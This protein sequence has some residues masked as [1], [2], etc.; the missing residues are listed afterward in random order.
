MQNVEGT[1]ESSVKSQNADIAL[2]QQCASL[3]LKDYGA[4]AFSS[5][6]LLCSVVALL[7]NFLCRHLMRTLTAKLKF[8]SLCQHM[9]HWFLA[10]RT[11]R[12]QASTSSWNN[13]HTFFLHL[14]QERATEQF[15]ISVISQWWCF[16]P[17]LN[18]WKINVTND[19]RGI[20]SFFFLLRT[21][22]LCRTKHVI[23]YV[24]QCN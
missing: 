2:E 13:I 7:R 17:L 20:F 21:S 24:F 8:K 15:F 14:L 5:S 23:L 19:P 6:L 11:I 16:R 22:S 1:D 3:G 4:V 10:K 12:A 18:F 9:R